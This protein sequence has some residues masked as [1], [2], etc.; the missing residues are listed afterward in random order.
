MAVDNTDERETWLSPSPRLQDHPPLAGSSRNPRELV[1]VRS[2]LTWANDIVR[3]SARCNIQ[4]PPYILLPRNHGIAGLFE[5]V[6]STDCTNNKISRSSKWAS[7]AY[8]CDLLVA[9]QLEAMYEWFV[10]LRGTK[11]QQQVP[12]AIR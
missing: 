4:L 5:T 2:K 9:W 3:R 8:L 11:C 10:M 12:A 7:L 6:T 1:I